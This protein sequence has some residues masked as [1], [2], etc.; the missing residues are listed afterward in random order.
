MHAA[1]LG[2]GSLGVYTAAVHAVLDGWV[3]DDSAPAVSH[4]LAASAFP[5]APLHVAPRGPCSCVG[6]PPETPLLAAARR[7]ADGAS[8]Q[9]GVLGGTTLGPQADSALRRLPMVAC[10]AVAVGTG[11]VSVLLLWLASVAQLPA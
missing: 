8:V 9:R 2:L 10:G 1:G 11:G 4:A 3:Q 6:L 5:A 7:A